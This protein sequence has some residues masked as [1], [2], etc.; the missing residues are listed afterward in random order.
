M[1]WANANKTGVSEDDGKGDGTCKIVQAVIF[2]RKA[3]TLMKAWN[4]KPLKSEIL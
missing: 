3:I 4:G 2:S 1:Y